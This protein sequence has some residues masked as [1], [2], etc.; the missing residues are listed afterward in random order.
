MQSPNQ[1][2]STSGP[3][4]SSED[5]DYSQEDFSEYGWLRWVAQ[6]LAEMDD[7][8]EVSRP[9]LWIAAQLLEALHRKRYQFDTL[10]CLGAVEDAQDSLGHAAFEWK[11]RDTLLIVA[12]LPEGFIVLDTESGGKPLKDVKPE[13]LRAVIEAV[14]KRL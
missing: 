12:C 3:T 5:P 2:T 11:H 9:S 14:E 6:D 10:P 4:T 13:P 7:T 8:P 1:S